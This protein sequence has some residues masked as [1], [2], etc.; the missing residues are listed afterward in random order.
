MHRY[1][2]YEEV[3]QEVERLEFVDAQAQSRNDPVQ[4]DSESEHDPDETEIGKI[5]IFSVLKIIE[6]KRGQK[7][8]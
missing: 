2:S 1:S 7:G 5:P 8:S 4:E 6:N 3:S